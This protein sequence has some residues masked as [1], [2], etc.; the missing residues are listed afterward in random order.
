MGYHRHLDTVGWLSPEKKENRIMW[1]FL[2]WASKEMVVPFMIG[3]TKEEV[4]RGRMA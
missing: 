3:N 1:T 2:A 4:E